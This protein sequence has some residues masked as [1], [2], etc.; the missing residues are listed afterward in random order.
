MFQT[1]NSFSRDL[2][3]GISLLYSYSNPSP[4]RYS[5]SYVPAPF[6]AQTK[7]MYSLVTDSKGI[8]LAD[9]T[10]IQKKTTSIEKVNSCFLYGASI[11]QEFK[12]TAYT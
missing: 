10:Y 7:A 9:Y 8:R 1:S 4:R 11:F 6:Y 3:T 5:G 2:Q 12:P